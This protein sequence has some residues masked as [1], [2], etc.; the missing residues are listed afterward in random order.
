MNPTSYQAA[1]VN[2]TSYQ[3]ADVNP[4]SYQPAGV[5]PISLLL[6]ARP[7]FHTQARVH[8]RVVVTQAAVVLFRSL[9]SLFVAQAPVVLQVQ[10]AEEE[11]EEAPAAAGTFFSRLLPATP[12]ASPT[13][14]PAPVPTPAA[15]KPSV[16]S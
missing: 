10:E 11:V 4:T 1:G 5:N 13:P 9:T 6:S 2:P 12:K 15:A 8:V 7:S 3:P 16:S 14:A